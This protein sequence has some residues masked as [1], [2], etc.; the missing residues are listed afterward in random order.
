MESSTPLEQ[1]FRALA[2]VLTSSDC[3]AVWPTAGEGLVGEFQ[4]LVEEEWQQLLRH[5]LHLVS[6]AEVKELYCLQNVP[7]YDE[8]VVRVFRLVQ[9]P[10]PR[11]GVWQ[12]QEL[13][14]TR[15]II[16]TKSELSR[17]DST[18]GDSLPRSGNG[19]K[20]WTISPAKMQRKRRQNSDSEDR[21]ASSNKSNDEVRPPTKTRRVSPEKKDRAA[22]VAPIPDNCDSVGNTARSRRSGQSDAANKRHE[23][24]AADAARA[25]GLLHQSD[26]VAYADDT[27]PDQTRYESLNRARVVSLSARGTESLWSA[28]ESASTRVLK[29]LSNGLFSVVMGIKTQDSFDYDLL[30]IEEDD[31]HCWT[32]FGEPRIP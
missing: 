18:A 14:G 28:L 32:M 8:L 17:S 12:L 29:L 11:R 23:L 3:V 7:G 30:W 25:L 4:V 24:R 10:F 20:A 31:R 5:G 13:P 16:K 22:P 26:T 2:G 15:Q 27:G 1:D 9:E 21:V 19:S 6:D